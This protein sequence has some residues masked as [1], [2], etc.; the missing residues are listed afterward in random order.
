MSDTCDVIVVTCVQCRSLETR[1][2]VDF[3]VEVPGAPRRGRFAVESRGS[4]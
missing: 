1:S 4:R 3:A 2:S